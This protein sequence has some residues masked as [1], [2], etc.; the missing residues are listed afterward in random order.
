MGTARAQAPSKKA[1]T[2]SPSAPTTSTRV[3]FGG[4]APARPWRYD[5]GSG[6]DGGAE[7]A[8][9]VAHQRRAE[10]LAQRVQDRACPYVHA[11]LP[12][13]HLLPTDDLQVGEGRHARAATVAQ[14]HPREVRRPDDFHLQDVAV[15]PG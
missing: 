8:I 6:E 1:P 13:E 4:V 15:R 7:V 5:R 12:G 10:G 11:K 14:R 2:A 3:R 9:G